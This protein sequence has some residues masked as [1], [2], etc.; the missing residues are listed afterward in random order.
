M[1]RAGGRADAI[2]G[3]DRDNLT[4]FRVVIA[5]PPWL[6]SRGGGAS[7]PNSRPFQGGVN[8]QY[9][10][11]TNA[12][13]CELGPWVQSV[14]ARNSVLLMWATFP[15][16]PEAFEVMT[17]W[18]FT[19]KTAC[20]WV[21]TAPGTGTIRRGVG[22]WFQGAAEILLI[23]TRGN[24]K[25]L[26]TGRTK[27]IGLTVGEPRE[28]WRPGGSDQQTF[29]APATR[30]SVKHDDIHQYAEDNL[31]GPYLELFARRRRENWT[32]LGHE[33]GDH[34]TPAGPEAA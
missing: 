25:K 7:K 26:K 27:K 21:K 18:G 14:T 6:Y 9:P 5:D 20:P 23:G 31:V 2:P 4:G 28:F 8:E 24:G 11:M 33:L 34:L 22:F 16:L 15:K 30:H 12:D 17:A 13:I 10:T 32:C 1:A 29:F 3:R 19:H